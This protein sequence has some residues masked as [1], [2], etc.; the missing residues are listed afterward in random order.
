MEE[1]KSS[2]E[3]P[4]Q[5]QDF[6]QCFLDYFNLEILTVYYKHFT[7]IMSIG[8]TFVFKF[9]PQIIERLFYLAKNYLLHVSICLKKKRFY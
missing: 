8:P 3:I 2:G 7:L 5:L 9:E 6:T 1:P 4:V